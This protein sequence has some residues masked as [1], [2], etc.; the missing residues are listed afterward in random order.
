MPHDGLL[1]SLGEH[2]CYARL[3]GGGERLPVFSLALDPPPLGD[4][5]LAQRLATAAA[6]RSGR[7]REHVLQVRA[8]LRARIDAARQQAVAAAQRRN[9][10]PPPIPSKGNAST[11][12]P[13]APASLERPRLPLDD[14][15]APT[16]AAPAK[17]TEGQE[18]TE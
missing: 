12:Q 13:G 8:T 7:P 16:D 1:V 15:P 18:G 11:P 9:E 2:R 10:G 14:A 6:R 17:D 5:V 3:S 4:A